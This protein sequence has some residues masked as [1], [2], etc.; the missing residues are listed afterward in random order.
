MG[1]GPFSGLGRETPPDGGVRFGAPLRGGPGHA[2]AIHLGYRDRWIG[3]RWRAMHRISLFVV[4]VLIS[5]GTLAFETVKVDD[6]VYALMGDLGQRSPENLGHNMT[7]GFVVADNGVVVIDTGGCRLGAEAIH[8]AI[9]QVT[10]KPVIWAVNTGGQDHR[11]LG[12][13]YFQELGVP[14]IA[15]EA[16]QQDMINRTAQQVERARRFI[17]E[18][19]AG[20]EPVYPTRTF[21]RRFTLPVDGVTIELIYPGGGQ[22]AG[23][24]FVW[25]PDHRTVFTG[26]VVFVQR[27]LRVIPG[28]GFRW[29]ASLEFLRDR[30][31][32]EVVI[33]GHGHVTDM[34]E[35]L[36]DSYQYLVFL[37]DAAQHALDQG[38]FDPVEASQGLDQSQFSHLEHYS[39]LRLRSTNALHMA[40]EIFAAAQE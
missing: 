14:I 23:D 38:A 40:E 20:T 31:R 24:T 37:R 27:M 17:K 22:T 10:D 25:L 8:Q 26:D 18:G 9:K 33:P 6:R 21:E 36:R 7:S 5:F 1:D 15:A 28:S 13:G 11:W 39:D 35:A 16:A 2:S 30:V 4:L 12:N 19:F 3:S 34:T 29:I 32:P